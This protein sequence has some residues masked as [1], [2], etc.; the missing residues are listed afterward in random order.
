M[1]GDKTFFECPKKVEYNS[2]MALCS[3]VHPNAVS[4]GRSGRVCAGA[5]PCCGVG[6]RG[7]VPAEGEMKAV[8]CQPQ[9]LDTDREQRHPRTRGD[10]TRT[11]QALVCRELLLFC[12]PLGSS[13]QT[14]TL[15]GFFFV[16]GGVVFFYSFKKILCRFAG[17]ILDNLWLLF[18]GDWRLELGR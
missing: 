18:D 16:L 13:Q 5:W 12:W 15:L 7:S 14:G 2:A 6:H 4:P 10:T 11:E 9:P 17:N 3:F 8:P 1:E